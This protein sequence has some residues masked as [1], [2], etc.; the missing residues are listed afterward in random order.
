MN[1]FKEIKS[2]SIVV[3]QQFLEFENNSQKQRKIGILYQ[4]CDQNTEQQMLQNTGSFENFEQFLSILG[5][6]IQIT[7]G[8][9]YYTG[10][11]DAKGRDGD[12]LYTHLLDTE[13]AF[14]VS[15][16]LKHV[17]NDDQQL[18]KKRHIGNDNIIILFQEQGSVYDLSDFTSQ[19][20]CVW[21][22]IE[23]ISSVSLNEQEILV[24]VKIFYKTFIE[25]AGQEIPPELTEKI[26]VNK[27]FLATF[28]LQ[29]LLDI[30]KS[31]WC[32]GEFQLKKQRQRISLIDKVGQ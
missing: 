32:S 28:L 18:I 10:G 8:L 4:K 9:T 16:W 14:H 23:Q 13:L 31:I 27:N 15:T 30:S 17:N 1:D 5:Q 29:K 25:F 12:V 20:T 6:R 3:L 21:V 22:V 2:P 7:N 19:M 24:S 26:L 11:L